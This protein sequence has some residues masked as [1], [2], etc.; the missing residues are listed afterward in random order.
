M[1]VQYFSTNCD[2]SKLIAFDD[3]FLLAIFNTPTF[4]NRSIFYSDDTFMSVSVIYL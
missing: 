3:E 1:L 4:N 2:L